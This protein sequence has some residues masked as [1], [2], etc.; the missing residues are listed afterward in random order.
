MASFDFDDPKLFGEQLKAALEETYDGLLK[1]ASEAATETTRRR[2][3]EDAFSPAIIP[4]EDITDSQ[5]DYFL[6]REDP[7]IICEMEMDSFGAK[8][9]SFDDSP[10]TVP[11][12][13]DKYLLVFYSNTTAEFVKDVNFLRTYRS[14]VRDMLIDNTLRDLS[15]MKDFKFM[16]GVEQIVGPA[17]GKRSPLT[18][19][20]QNIMYPGR[21]NK[22]NWVSATL[23]LG[24]SQLMNGVFL[25]NRRTFAELRRWGRNE[26]GG[27]FAEECALKGAGAFQT[28]KFG[29]V[30]FIVTQQNDLVPNGA[31]YEFTQP[32]YLGRAGVL[33]KPTMYVKRDKDLIHM[34]CKEILGVSI[35]NLAG[36]R[37]V[38]FQ[39]LC[40]ADG[41][42]MRLTLDAEGNL[43][44]PTTAQADWGAIERMPR[45][46]A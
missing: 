13:G 25:C 43:N 36:V 7:A 15:R 29:G 12:Y 30:D 10:D 23:L 21:L 11:F 19:I 28:S 46:I 6:E 16:A 20:E 2:V 24:D 39:D 14:D 3:R 26:M 1:E 4:H 9:I 42:D 32:N 22:N 31:M 40:S 41:G 45:H 38:Q 18:N 5:L 34:S 17:A 33:Q 35:A 8:S 27:D 37:K 44:T